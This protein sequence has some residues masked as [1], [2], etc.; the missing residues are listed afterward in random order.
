MLFFAGLFCAYTIYRAQH[1]EVFVCAHYFLDTKLGALNTIVLLGSAAS[2]PPGPFAALSSANKKALII[3]IVITIACACTFM[4]V[5]YFEYTHKF[6]D[7]L[8]WGG[9]GE[10]PI[11]GLKFNPKEE[12][13]E[14]PRFQHKH[15]EA[16]KIAEEMRKQQARARRSAR[17]ERSSQCRPR[18]QVPAG[19]AEKPEQAPA[20]PAAVGAASTPRL[21]VPL[22]P[23]RSS[24]SLRKPGRCNRRA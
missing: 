20:Q 8:V 2:P 24:R 17:L 11:F 5:K 19:G 6:H 12:V 4:V 18:G 22:Q 23:P 7:G 10:K 21:G 14:L 13:W 9:R 1:P 3:N 16:A 15:P